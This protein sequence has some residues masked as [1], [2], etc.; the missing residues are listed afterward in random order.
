MYT[1]AHTYNGTYTD[2]QVIAAGG[3]IT[4]LDAVPPAV[5]DYHFVS[6]EGISYRV[7][8]KTHP[9]TVNSPAWSGNAGAGARAPAW[10]KDRSG[11]VHLQGAVTQTNPSAANPNL[12]GTLP[13][14]AAPATET[15]YTI[16][17]T[18]PGTY[19]D[20]MIQA[21]GA[22]SVIDPRVPA[23]KN[24]AYLSLESIT[25]RADDAGNGPIPLASGWSGSAGFNSRGPA[26]FRDTSGLIHLEGAVGQ[27]NTTGPSLI[28]TLPAAATPRHDVYTIVHTLAG[29]YADL[30]ITRRGQI[31]R[32]NPPSALVTDE[33]FVSLESIVYRR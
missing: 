2:L 33:R 25:Y 9:I 31:R 26:W 14:A 19:A 12:L 22:I 18:A 13:A 8:G 16:A 20:V 21:S 32:I 3:E 7:S 15:L 23:A 6:L 11:V 27:A 10:Y 29:T 5:S 4:F 17:I 30:D 1:I 24:Y 28:G